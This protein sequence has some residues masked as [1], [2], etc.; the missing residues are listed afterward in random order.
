MSQHAQI[1][2]Q[3]TRRDRKMMIGIIA[4][5]A[6]VALIVVTGFAF[7]SDIITGS[8]SATAGTLDITGTIE[9]SQNGTALTNNTTTNLN[10]G[11]VLTF[12]GTATNAGSK[13]AWIRQIVQFTEL[14]S[15][16]NV[17]GVCSDTSYTDKTTC[18]TASETWTAGA[19]I[20]DGNLADY[21][22]VC[23]GNVTQATLI[24]ASTTAGGMATNAPA[25]CTKVATADVNTDLGLATAFGKTTGFAAPADVISGSVET[26]GNGTTWTPVVA[27]ALTIYFDAAAPNAAQ[28]GKMSFS[29]S[30]Q[31]LQYRNNT[32]LS[33]NAWS[34]VVTTP[35]AL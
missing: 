15:T 14:S 21:I 11:D 25:T 26:D 35:F 16:N 7:F 22:W 5:F 27:N 4:L 1:T 17:G 13:S 33:A 34:T 10:P 20:A 12:S 6:A 24:T 9:A 2:Q 19:A 32:T 23:T 30:T 8:G 28:N 3:D 18:E 31:A 29:V